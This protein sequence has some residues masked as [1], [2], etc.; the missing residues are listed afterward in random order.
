MAAASKPPRHG[1]SH[2]NISHT[3]FGRIFEDVE[4]LAAPNPCIIDLLLA[5]RHG[6]EQWRQCLLLTEGLDD[7]YPY[8]QVAYDEYCALRS[9]QVQ[10]GDAA[11]RLRDLHKLLQGMWISSV[12]NLQNSA[13]SEAEI[14]ML[15]LSRETCLVCGDRS[16]IRSAIEAQMGRPLT[17]VEISLIGDRC[18][19]GRLQLTL[20]RLQP[21]NTALVDLARACA[22]LQRGVRGAAIRAV[23]CLDRATTAYSVASRMT[24]TGAKASRGGARDSAAK[25]PTLPTATDIVPSKGGI[26][27]RRPSRQGQF[28]PRLDRKARI[29]LRCYRYAKASDSYI[30]TR[31]GMLR[32]IYSS[33]VAPHAFRRLRLPAQIMRRLDA[34]LSSLKNNTVVGLDEFE[35]ALRLVRTALCKLL[36]AFQEAWHRYE[37]IKLLEK[38]TMTPPAEKDKAPAPLPPRQLTAH[39]DSHN[40]RVFFSLQGG[41]VT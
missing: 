22:E 2:L 13:C 29:K 23:A 14:A 28:L 34:V 24:L 21:E 11:F 18:R 8:S 1:R 27:L 10:P 39:D 9:E 30:G 25:L 35:P 15:S 4:D 20:Q 38:P 19:G 12:V 32:D 37:R 7:T 31:L 17:D 26:R 16:A 41:L 40:K 6:F 33:Y 3:A 5:D 36:P